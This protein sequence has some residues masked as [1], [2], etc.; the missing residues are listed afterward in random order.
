MIL[1]FIGLYSLIFLIGASFGSFIAAIVYRLN[2]KTK[3]KNFKKFFLSRSRCDECGYLLGFFDLV[4]IFSFLLL[5][6]K[7]RKCKKSLKIEYFVLEC[8]C[9]FLAVCVLYNALY[10]AIPYLYLIWISFLIFFFVF[11][12]YYDYLYWEIPLETVVVV[13]LLVF[14]TQ[15]G[16]LLIGAFEPAFFMTS[17]F[18]MIVG[19][20]FVA[21]VI[22]ISK[23]R[24][25]GWGD[26]WILGLVGL[27]LQI[28]GVIVVVFLSLL[29]GALFGI[30]YS[31]LSRKKLKGMLIQFVPFICLGVI[32]FILDHHGFVSSLIIPSL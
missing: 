8:I 18:A 30:V 1:E 13:L 15:L 7:C 20:L 10:F 26:A 23:G 5:G 24:G 6:G 11:L 28:R 14:S 2:P 3:R 16:G 17:F 27:S 32:I 4:P 31:L 21:L 29:F 19:I 25:L 9:G 12:A 22:Y